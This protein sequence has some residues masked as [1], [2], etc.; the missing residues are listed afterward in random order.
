MVR[1]LAW[2]MGGGRRDPVVIVVSG[3][4]VFVGSLRG[5]WRSGTYHSAGAADEEAGRRTGQLEAG[6]CALVA[7]PEVFFVD[8][9]DGVGAVRSSAVGSLGL[10]ELL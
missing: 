10:G 6:G 7:G 4:R 1:A 5:V 3:R 9:G 8:D 2:A